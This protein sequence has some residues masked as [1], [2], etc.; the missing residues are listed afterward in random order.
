MNFGQ[1][2]KTKVAKYSGGEHTVNLSKSS[3]NSASQEAIY[4]GRSYIHRKI[5]LRTKYYTELANIDTKL[6]LWY[7]SVADYRTLLVMK[8]SFASATK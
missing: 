6:A 2:T 8:I 5:E 1:H 3:Y 4:R 7:R